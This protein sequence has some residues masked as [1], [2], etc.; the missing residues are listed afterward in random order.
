MLVSMRSARS[1]R[2]L[3]I[4]FE[5]GAVWLRK[6]PVKP[7]CFGHIVERLTSAAVL[8]DPRRKHSGAADDSVQGMQT[9]RDGAAASWSRRLLQGVSAAEATLVSF[10]N[11]LTAEGRLLRVM[12]L[13]TPACVESTSLVLSA[14]GK[15]LATA[16]RI[17]RRGKRP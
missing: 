14:N 10:P 17:A 15:P 6:R 5:A 1:I 2:R 9:S 8:W 13:V 11:R 3:W 12:T 4:N 16:P 7:V